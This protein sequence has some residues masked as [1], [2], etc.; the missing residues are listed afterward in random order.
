V[1]ILAGIFVAALLQDLS[2]TS[3]T[4]L[5]NRG[6]RTLAVAADIS[7]MVTSSLYLIL[8]A[9]V[10]MRS[11]L[12]VATVE[13]FAAIAAGGACGTLGG[14]FAMEWLERRLQFHAQGHFNPKFADLKGR[15]GLPQALATVRDCAFDSPV[16]RVRRRRCGLA[17]RPPSPT[18]LLLRTRRPA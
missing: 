7:A 10:T 11:G 4:V 16:L 12:S 9:S 2:Y 6:Q 8:T 5:V 18:R 14:M 17:E 3:K 15:G 1:E 13:A